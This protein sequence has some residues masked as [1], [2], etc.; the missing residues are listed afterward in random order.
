MECKGLSFSGKFAYLKQY[1]ILMEKKQYSIRNWPEVHYYADW[2]EDLEI[3]Q[4]SEIQKQRGAMTW[5][6]TL[7]VQS[8]LYLEKIFTH[9]HNHLQDGQRDWNTDNISFFIDWTPSITSAVG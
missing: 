3:C 7:S 9:S 2:F 6:K 4:Y 1:L 8:K 5:K